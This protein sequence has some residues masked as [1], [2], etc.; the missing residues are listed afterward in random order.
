M[1]LKFLN[2]QVINFDNRPEIYEVVD[3]KVVFW[4][5]SR[6]VRTLMKNLAKNEEYDFDDRVEAS[7]LGVALRD[8]TEDEIEITES[9]LDL[10]ET[11]GKNNCHP[12]LL[13]LFNMAISES[14]K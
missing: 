2:E 6:I 5:F 14:K 7:N 1:R 11:E 10:I 3:D 8:T 4:T 12:V 13:E 9:Q